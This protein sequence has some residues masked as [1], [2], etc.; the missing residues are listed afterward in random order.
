MSYENKCTTDSIYPCMCTHQTGEIC[1]SQ[2][3]HSTFWGSKNC[4]ECLWICFPCTL[5]IDIL[6]LVPFTSIY[7]CKK[8]CCMKTSNMEQP[9]TTQPY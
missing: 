1:M 3:M 6:T 7:I 9:I 2:C 8:T 5:V 4:H